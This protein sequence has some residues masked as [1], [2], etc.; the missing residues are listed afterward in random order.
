MISDPSEPVLRLVSELRMVPVR[1]MGAST[2]A[3]VPPTLVNRVVLIP[4]LILMLSV[5]ALPRVTWPLLPKLALTRFT[6][7]PVRATG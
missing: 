7:E 4:V 2:V 6:L 3:S 1:L 5:A